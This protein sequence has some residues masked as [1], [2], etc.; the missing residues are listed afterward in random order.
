MSD[1]IQSA[2][3]LARA[4]NGLAKDI[5]EAW[6]CEESQLGEYSEVCKLESEIVKQQSLLIESRDAAIRA[7]EARKHAERDAKTFEAIVYSMGQAQIFGNDIKRE[8]LNTERWAK[9]ALANLEATK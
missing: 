8:I 9:R 3:K 1:T 4:L 2:E 6:E 5:G 7:D